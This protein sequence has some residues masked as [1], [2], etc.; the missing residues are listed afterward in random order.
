MLACALLVVWVLPSL[1]AC[2]SLAALRSKAVSTSFSAPF[3]SGLWYE[4]RYT[5]LAQIGARCQMMNKTAQADGSISEDY[6]VYYGNLPFPLPL[7]YNATPG[8]LGVSSRYMTLFPFLQFPSVV[9]DFDVSQ[10]NGTYSALIEYLCWDVL[11]IDYVEVRIST[12]MPSPPPAYLDALEARAR[13]L[14]VSWSGTLT[15]VNFTGCPAFGAHKAALAAAAAAPTPARPLRLPKW[16]KVRA[17]LAGVSLDHA[18]GA[19]ARAGAAISGGVVPPTGS[20]FRDPADDVVLPGTRPGL[21]QLALVFIQGAECPPSAYTPLLQALQAA[22]TDYDVIVGAPDAPLIHT[23]DP[24]SIGL[25][26]ARILAAMEA[27]GGLVL[28]NSST[29]VAFAAHSLGGLMLLDWVAVADFVTYTPAAVLLLGSYITRSLRPGINASLSTPPF[30][31]P[32]L[33]IVGELDG[34]ARVNRFAEAAWWQQERG[35]SPALR[36]AFPVLYVPGM[37]HGQWASFPGPPPSEVAAYDLAPEVPDAQARSAGAALLA[38]YLSVT[39]SGSNAPPAAGAALD[40]AQASASAFFAPLIAASLYEASYNFIPPCYDAPPSAACSVGS[41]FSQDAQQL[42]S[43]TA[44][45]CLNATAGGTAY[46]FTASVV[47]ALHPV[48]DL[49]PIHLP[50]ITNQCAAPTPACT[51]HASTV[52]ENAYDPLYS[53]LD[54]ALYPTSPHEAKVKLFSR[55]R[56]L[57]HAGVPPSQA[58]FNVTDA[59]S[60]CGEINAFTFAAALAAAAPATAA[61]F[62]RRGL[63]LRFGPDA[64]GF[65]GPQFTDG[66]LAFALVKNYTSGTASGSAAA[67][68]SDGG[69]GSGGRA[70]VW[71]NST[72]LPTPFPYFVPLAEGMHYCL[73]L[74]PSRALE[75][76]YTDGLRSTLME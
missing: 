12:R 59:P 3:T 47:D 6:K 21:P 19:G 45:H 64:I 56:T 32:T 57:L 10:G 53:E 34:L 18:A 52:T 41:P 49:H 30:R 33:S 31:F 71:V 42:L 48:A 20:P 39:L 27:R 8:E 14:G 73:L 63:P 66:S 24:I 28:K 16:A 44:G 36:R 69:V 9:V 38:A 5:D 2:P 70:F 11:G 55:Q 50:N 4:N 72:S 58:P 75:W 15:S 13:A 17:A 22:V 76:V 1:A 37:N 40:A 60:Y 51:L 62:T 26:V 67:A 54:V 74:T 25:D 29:R 65:A 35:I 46:P 68:S 7:Y 43:N 23:P 61:R